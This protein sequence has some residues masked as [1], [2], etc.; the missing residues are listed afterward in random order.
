MLRR[1]FKYIGDKM[2]DIIDTNEKIYVQVGRP[3]Y[4]ALAFFLINKSL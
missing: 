3:D 1:V 2:S 4:F